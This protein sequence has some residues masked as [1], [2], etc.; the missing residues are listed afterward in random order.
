ML[1]QQ[2]KSDASLRQASLHSVSLY[3]ISLAPINESQLGDAEN[4]LRLKMRM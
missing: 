1:Y 4:F 3:N 2:L